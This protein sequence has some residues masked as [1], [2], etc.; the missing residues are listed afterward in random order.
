MCCFPAERW[1]FPGKINLAGLLRWSRGWKIKAWKWAK[2][3]KFSARAAFFFVKRKKAMRSWSSSGTICTL[4]PAVVT[5]CATVS[6]QID[7]VAPASH[8]RHPED[9]LLRS[10]E[11]FS[12]EHVPIFVFT[13][14]SSIS[15]HRRSLKYFTLLLEPSQ[16]ENTEL[17]NKNDCTTLQFRIL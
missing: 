2:H 10:Q 4:L 8:P 9:A 17:W 7:R 11:K 5:V 16:R 3:N 12:G 15:L 13:F 1:I 14:F 6:P